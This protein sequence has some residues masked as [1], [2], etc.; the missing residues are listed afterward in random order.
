MIDTENSSNRTRKRRRFTQ[1]FGTAIALA[2]FIVTAMV[3][4]T[5]P[6]TAEAVGCWG[7]WCSGKDPVAT[8]C[9][10]GACAVA[11]VRIPGTSAYVQNIWSPT[12]KTQWARVSNSYGRA[13]PWRLSAVQQTGYRQAGAKHHSG[14]Y[15]WTNMIYTP[16]YCVSARW[17]GAQDPPAPPA[18]DRLSRPRQQDHKREGVPDQHR[19]EQVRPPTFIPNG[20]DPSDTPEN[21][22]P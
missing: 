15:S 8:G 1:R 2:T 14:Q 17:T 18:G 20:C 5:A 4:A 13:Y 19:S 3:S 10:R 22:T 16:N 21:R 9:A 12:C 6:K 7:D 11:H